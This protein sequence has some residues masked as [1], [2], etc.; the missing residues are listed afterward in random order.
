[1]SFMEVNSSLA[2]VM[3][4]KSLAGFGKI[5]ISQVLGLSIIM[6]FGTKETQGRACLMIN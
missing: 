1:M 5:V 2:L 6:S 4:T 3:F